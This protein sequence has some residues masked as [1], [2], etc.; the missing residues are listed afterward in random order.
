VENQD[1]KLMNARV[2]MQS[3]S[4]VEGLVANQLIVR[5]QLLVIV[6][7]AG[8]QRKLEDFFFAFSGDDAGEMD[9][10]IK[11]TCFI[12]NTPLITIIN[13][14]ATHSFIS[15]DCVKRLNLETSVMPG[16]MVIDTPAN[17]FVT[18]K[19]ACVNCPVYVF[20]KNFGMDLVCIPLSKLDVSCE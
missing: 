15:L 2:K 20:G 1:I 14:G 9:N 10:L 11:G 5:I 12:N 8:S 18:T 19:L 6:L 13:I 7:I 3:A 16:C 17:G 4:N